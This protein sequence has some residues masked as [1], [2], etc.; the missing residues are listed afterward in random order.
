MGRGFLPKV[1]SVGEIA[2]LNPA[3]SA[4]WRF[5]L[6]RSYNVGTCGLAVCA[7]GLWRVEALVPLWSV[8]VGVKFG[9]EIGGIHVFDGLFYGFHLVVGVG[10]RVVPNGS[11]FCGLAVEGGG[12]GVGVESA[13]A[14]NTNRGRFRTTA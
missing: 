13:I 1:Q 3:E 9:G 6:C 5:V 7:V 12:A 11:L 14:A 10:F 4:S 8:G 2:S